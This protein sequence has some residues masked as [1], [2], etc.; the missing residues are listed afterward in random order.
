[1]SQLGCC[2][3]SSPNLAD[4]LASSSGLPPLPL[5]LAASSAAAASNGSVRPLPEIDGV[6]LEAPLPKDTTR[7]LGPPAKGL[8][9]IWGEGEGQVV[10]VACPE[11]G[12]ATWHPNRGSEKHM[13][14]LPEEEAP[15]TAAQSC[16]SR[17]PHRR[18]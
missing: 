9:G 18:R 13:H 12:A 3:S 5:P 6:R 10:A 4:R 16:A 2:L 15:P 7:F 14:G 17:A 11:V 8:K 1:M